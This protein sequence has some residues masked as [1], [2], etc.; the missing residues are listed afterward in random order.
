MIA[1]PLLLTT[2]YDL[3]HARASLWLQLAGKGG[4]TI[5]QIAKW[6]GHSP[7]VLM[8]TYANCVVGDESAALAALDAAEVAFSELVQP[9]C[10]EASEPFT[11][12]EA[13]VA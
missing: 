10:N 12:T 2:H 9:Q 4:M 7:E 8:T 5:P 11:A 13:E 6:L 3:R 1:N